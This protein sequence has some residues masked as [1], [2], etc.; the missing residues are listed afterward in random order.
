MNSSQSELPV[1]RCQLLV[2]MCVEM[3]IKAVDG[4]PTNGVEGEVHLF[5]QQQGLLKNAGPLIGLGVSHSGFPQHALLVW[6]PVGEVSAIKGAR[7]VGEVKKSDRMGEPGLLFCS[8]AAPWKPCA[9][10][11]TTSAINNSP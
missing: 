8:Q 7:V 4:T 10:A 6:L 1:A 11:A 2:I 9:L 3:A 5:H